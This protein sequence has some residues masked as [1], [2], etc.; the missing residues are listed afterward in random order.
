MAR[1]NRKA[2]RGAAT[3]DVLGWWNPITKDLIDIQG[4]AARDVPTLAEAIVIM[5]DRFS[6]NVLIPEI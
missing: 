5:R 2:I 4:R 6:W 1:T 3:N